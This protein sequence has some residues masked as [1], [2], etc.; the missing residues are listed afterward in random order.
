MLKHLGIALTLQYSDV[1]GSEMKKRLI[2]GAVFALT[3]SQLLLVLPIG[4]AN[5]HN[6]G[7]M[8]DTAHCFRRLDG[9]G[10]VCALLDHPSAYPAGVA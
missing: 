1:A 9:I 2:G 7:R 6:F 5:R 4:I 8:F 3:A 10:V